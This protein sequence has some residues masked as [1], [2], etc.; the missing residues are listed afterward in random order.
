MNKPVVE[1]IGIWFF[2]DSK[3]FA[4]RSDQVDWLYKELLNHA[5]SGV[6][7]MVNIYMYDSVS[8]M[9][10]MNVWNQLNDEMKDEFEIE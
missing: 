2:R 3:R 9:I 5:S 10:D 6:R 7:N 1:K 8:Q 4:D